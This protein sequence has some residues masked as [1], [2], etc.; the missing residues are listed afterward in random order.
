MHERSMGKWCGTCE[1]Q[2]VAKKYWFASEANV[3]VVHYFLQSIRMYNLLIFTVF[4]NKMTQEVRS[5]EI[6]T[7][8]PFQLG[9][10]V[11]IKGQS[12]ELG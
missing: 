3:Q 7:S 4:T 2:T 1:L 8:Y 9:Y 6:F 12:L 5:K 11:L 10:V